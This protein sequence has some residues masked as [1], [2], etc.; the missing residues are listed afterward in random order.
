MWSMDVIPF[1]EMAKRDYRFSKQSFVLA[2]CGTNEPCAW[3]KNVVGRAYEFKRKKGD[4]G[5]G[6]IPADDIGAL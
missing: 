3:Q 6:V 5:D 4:K 2:E 1:G